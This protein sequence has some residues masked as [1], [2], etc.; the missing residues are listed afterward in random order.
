MTKIIVVLYSTST[1]LC[2][3]HIMWQLCL[4]NPRSSI[5]TEIWS[6]I[7]LP[8]SFLLEVS[9]CYF[10]LWVCPYFL[11]VKRLV[12]LWVFLELFL[13]QYHILLIGLGFYHVGLTFFWI[14]ENHSFPVKVSDFLKWLWLWIRSITFSGKQ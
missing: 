1:T 5:N 8:W 11:F 4:R 7:S 6:R 3:Y 2:T 9:L 12:L 13:G 14:I 10:N